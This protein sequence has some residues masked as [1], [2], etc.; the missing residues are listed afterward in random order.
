MQ[1]LRRKLAACF[2]CLPELEDGP[3]FEMAFLR[4][5]AVASE[6]PCLALSSFEQIRTV[7]CVELSSNH[8][9]RALWG[10]WLFEPC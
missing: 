1:E 10:P 9:M 2:A 3:L 8:A 7:M 5:F 6:R 4:A